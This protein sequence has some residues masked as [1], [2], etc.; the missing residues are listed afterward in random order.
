MSRRRKAFGLAAA[1]TGLWSA[2]VLACASILLD[3]RPFAIRDPLA[4]LADGE[5]LIVFG[6]AVAPVWA[7]WTVAA[8]W[9][10]IR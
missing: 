1:M 3:G 9:A 8:L 6:V 4:T 10:K 7:I 5:S 2:F